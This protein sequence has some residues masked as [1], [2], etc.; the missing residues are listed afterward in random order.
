M[1]NNGFYIEKLILVGKDIEPAIV[2]FQKG[3]NVVYGPSDTGKTFI[4]QC[5]QFLL[6]K[7]NI[8]KRIPESKKYTNAYLQIKTYQEKAQ[9]Y[10]IE[11]LLN[12]GDYGIFDL[13]Y[14]NI[15]EEVEPSIYKQSDFSSFLLDICNMNGKKARKNTNGETKT[16]TFRMLQHFFLL[17]ET[18]LQVEMSPIQKEQRTD[19]TYLENIFKYLI[20]EI[21]DGDTVIKAEKSTIDKKNSRLELLDELIVSTEK[22]LSEYTDNSTVIEE[23]LTKLSNS[24]KETKN[25]HIELKE[26]YNEHQK[27]RTNLE[28]SIMGKK[29]RIN[30]LSELIKRANILKEQYLNDINRLKSTIEACQSLDLLEKSNCP[31]CNNPVEE[32]IDIQ[33]IVQSS[34][35]EIKKIE[36]L[37]DELLET[38]KMFENEQ[39]T[40]EK[41]IRSENNLV[42]DILGILENNINQS[43]KNTQEDLSNFFNK[44]SLLNTAQVLVKNLHKY[45]LDKKTISTFLERTKEN[46]QIEYQELNIT[47]LSPLIKKIK[48]ILEKINFPD[49]N[50]VVFSENSK[51]IV[52][53]DK[54]RQEFGKGYRALLY[55]VFIIA[56]TELLQEKS[57]Q[58]GLTIFDSP[59]VTYKPSADYSDDDTISVDLAKNLYNYVGDNF[60]ESQLIII[61]NTTPPENNKIHKI[62]F[63][64]NHKIGR[65][66]FIPIGV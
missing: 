48:Y 35:I 49:F 13:E 27:E 30:H 10:T 52:I 26:L 15:N 66:G 42:M 37:K 47:M 7:S 2:E 50:N 36:A 22:E 63:T 41:E 11:R 34:A 51:D 40:L 16:I 21:D 31:L 62:E 56:L 28:S 20:T 61:E 64:K 32:E 59:M 44:K 38:V 53:N 5:I 39:N 24:I 45:Q 46:K 9:S 18:E 14:E 1:N 8:P 58:I 54:G 25:K 57:F 65:Y 23:Q 29:S 3:C 6:G 12:G 4:F 17:G 43:I 60:L 19:K 55:S 33:S